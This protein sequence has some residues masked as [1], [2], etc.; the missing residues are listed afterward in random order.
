MSH[1]ADVL[2][3][4]RAQ[5]VLDNEVYAQAWA[6]IEQEIIRQWREARSQQDREQLHQLL[7]MHG[8]ARTALESV[9]RTGQVAQ[10]ELGRKLSRAEQI[11]QAYGT[12]WAA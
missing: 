2:R 12:R 1:E 10:A 11:G 7:M 4:N 5:E 3:G 8:K 6:E 9:M